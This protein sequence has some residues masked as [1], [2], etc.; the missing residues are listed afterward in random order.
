MTH[1]KLDTCYLRQI[2]TNERR[3]YYNLC[4]LMFTY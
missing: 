2:V 1:F 3:I 4:E